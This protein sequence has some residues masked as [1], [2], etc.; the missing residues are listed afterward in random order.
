MQN[1]NNNKIT[2]T[3]PCTN[4]VELHWLEQRW[5]VYHGYY[6]LVLESLGK[7]PTAA[8]IMIFGIIKAELH[9]FMSR[10]IK[11]ILIMPHD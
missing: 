10:K 2:P 6:E 5:L 4:T 1:I 9:I 8:D 7:T 3:T 11:K